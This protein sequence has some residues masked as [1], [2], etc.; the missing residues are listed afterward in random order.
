MIWSHEAG[1]AG[2][3]LIAL[4]HGAMDRSASMVLLSRRL[5]DTYRVLRYDQ[6]VRPLQRRRRSVHRRRPRRRPRRP[7]RGA[8]RRAVRAQL[9]R[10]CGAGARRASS[11]SGACRGRLRVAAVVVA[12]VAGQLRSAGW[13]SRGDPA[14]AAEQFMRR[15]VGDERWEALPEHARNARRDEGVALVEEV[16]DLAATAAVASRPGRGAGRGDVR[17]AHPESITAT[18]ATIS[19]SCCRTA[20]RSPSRVPATAARTPHPEAVAAV[21]CA[22]SRLGRRCE[23]QETA[24]VVVVVV[25]ASGPSR[26]RPSGNG[27]LL[28]EERARGVGHRSRATVPRTSSAQSVSSARCDPPA[29]RSP[30]GSRRSAPS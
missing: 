18:D 15:V 24:T 2:A 14:G 10:Q 26:R 22:S 21:S 23:R 3:P 9:R 4:V 5:D 6:R 27:D 8:A 29:R 13:P 25:G 7:A 28:A 30:A 17:R 20:R 11:R 1:P 16:T 19:P 12:V